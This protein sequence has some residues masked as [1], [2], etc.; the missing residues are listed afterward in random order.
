MRRA[1]TLPELMLV[2][3]LVGILLGMA[4]PRLSS[5]I[6]RIEVHAAAN[7]V[8]AAHNRARILAVTQGHVVVLSVDPHALIL[9]RQ[10]ETTAIWSEPGPEASGV[11]LKSPGAKFTFSPEGLTLGLS[12]ATLKLAR[13]SATRTVI[14]SRLGRIR[15]TS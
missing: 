4:V 9:R 8:V 3:A 6:D 10:R 14:I 1:F 7:R 15:I 2:L 5:A 13:G 12:N 11:T